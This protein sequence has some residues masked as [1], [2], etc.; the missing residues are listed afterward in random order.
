MKLPLIP[1]HHKSKA[2]QSVASNGPIQNIQ[3][4]LSQNSLIEFK[5]GFEAGEFRSKRDVQSL[6]NTIEDQYVHK[7]AMDKISCLESIRIGWKLPNH[8]LGPILQQVVPMLLQQPAKVHHLQL[9]IKSWIPLPTIHRL[10]SWHTLETLDL[11]SI[12]IRHRAVTDPRPADRGPFLLRR[13][14]TTP[15]SP[16]PLLGAFIS[17][18]SKSECSMDE[19][20]ISSDDRVLAAL[21]YLSPSIKTL[22]LVDCDLL[23]E[24]MPDLIQILRKKRHIR[25]LSLRDNRNLYM[26]GWETQVLPQLP[27]LRALDLSL[28]DLDPFDGL[29]L[30]AAIRQCSNNKSFL[31]GLSLAG[32]YRLSEAIPELVE[33]CGSSGIIELDCSFCDVQNKCQQQIF[34]TLANIQPCSLRSLKMQSVRI[35]NVAPLVDCIVKN[36]SLERLILDNPRDAFRLGTQGMYQLLEA[37]KYNYYLQV[38]HVDVQYDVSPKVLQ[39]MEQWMTLNKCG[40]SILVNDSRKYW[41]RVLANA[42]KLGDVDLFYWVLRNGVDQFH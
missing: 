35:T 11:R 17:P 4:K 37:V 6:L 5:V 39:E 22:K 14:H 13:H 2:D 23:V 15:S 10:V 20:F 12:R 9:M 7:L 34:T 32:N 3:H 21:P 26:N 8:A 27:F 25:V 36:T 18:A 19:G 30:A 24:D 31:Q 38:L 40:R 41:P 16:P 42:G 28:C 33:A 29:R 1:Q